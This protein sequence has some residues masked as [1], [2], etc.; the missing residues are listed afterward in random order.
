MKMEQFARLGFEPIAPIVQEELIK[1]NPRIVPLLQRYQGMGWYDIFVQLKGEEGYL[2]V[3]MGGENGWTAAN[4]DRKYAELRTG[5]MS[6]SD[7]MNSI[8]GK[9]WEEI[10][11][12]EE[13]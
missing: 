2:I 13:G 7:L 9:T 11:S 10:I 4:N 12:K 3:S 5:F 6:L 1:L 8:E